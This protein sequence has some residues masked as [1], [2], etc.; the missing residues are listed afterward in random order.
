VDEHRALLV[1]GIPE[2]L[3]LIDIKTILQPTLLLLGQFRLLEVAA[4]NQEKAKATLVD[5][6]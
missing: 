6:V 5:F 2:D 3:K 1:T 4:V